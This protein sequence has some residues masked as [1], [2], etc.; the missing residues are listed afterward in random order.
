MLSATHL[1][2]VQAPSPL[3]AMQQP[4]LSP[5]GFK[6]AVGWL[7]QPAFCLE[8]LRLDG[9]PCVVQQ[10]VATINIQIGS[11]QLHSQLTVRFAVSGQTSKPDTPWGRA[12][13]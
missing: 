13:M 6:V 2:L 8:R 1:V 4:L 10:A 9:K 7:R 12:K 5:Q 11:Q 3:V